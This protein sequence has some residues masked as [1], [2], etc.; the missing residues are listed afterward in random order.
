[1]EVVLNF[2]RGCNKLLYVSSTGSGKTW[3]SMFFAKLWGSILIVAPLLA[4][5]IQ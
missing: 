1:V 2:M 3:V 4:L 5:A